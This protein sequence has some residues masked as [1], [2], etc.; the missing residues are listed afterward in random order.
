MAPE[1]ARGENV[2]HRADVYALS[3]IVY[4]ALT[5]HPAFTGKDIPSTL[6]DVVYKAPTQPSQLTSLPSDVDRVVAIG[7]A[8]SA[9]DRF[10][11]A[12]ELVAAL[13]LAFGAG[14]PPT[15]RRRADEIVERWP[16]GARR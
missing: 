5:G 3:A 8:K 11:T 1:Q 14:L 12:L 2:D 15:V 4:R 10:Q 7:M 16:W 9:G 6:Y 13:E